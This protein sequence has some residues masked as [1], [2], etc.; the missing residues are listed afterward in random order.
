MRK[1]HLTSLAVCVLLLAF[2]GP[3]AA[4]PANDDFNS[5]TVISGLPFTDS[6]TVDATPASDDRVPAGRAERHGSECRR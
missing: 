3:A 2:A 4:Q 5:A 6:I 1:A